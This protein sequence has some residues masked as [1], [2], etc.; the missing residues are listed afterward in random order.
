[1]SGIKN[2]KRI[3]KN[4]NQLFMASF[5]EIN[6]GGAKICSKNCLYDY[7]RKNPNKGTF[8]KGIIPHNKGKKGWTNGGGFKKGHKAIGNFYKKGHPDFTKNRGEKMKNYPENMKIR[9]SVE[10]RLW[11]EAVFARD[12]WTC[13][14]TKIKGG[15]LHAHHIQNFAQFPELR[16]SID[17]GITLSKEAHRGFHKRY[18]NKNNTKE[19]L[20]EFLNINDK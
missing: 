19:Q 7:Q 3:C 16:T 11:R 8:K 15:K 12:N 20:E 14:K 6:R 2:K 5:G 10:F 9:M 1:M 18:G 13:Q 4:C 17:N